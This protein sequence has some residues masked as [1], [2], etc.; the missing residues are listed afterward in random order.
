[1]NNEDVIYALSP[2][3]LGFHLLHWLVIQLED[4]KPEVFIFVHERRC[5]QR[6]EI[7]TVHDKS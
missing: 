4:L 5:Y 1:M 7:Q 2:L 3:S 6:C